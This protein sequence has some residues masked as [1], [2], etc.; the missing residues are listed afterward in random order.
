MASRLD[1]NSISFKAIYSKAF[2]FWPLMAVVY[3]TTSILIG[4]GF[5]AL[6]IPG[7]IVM[8]RTSYAQFYCV[9]E[10]KGPIEAIKKSWNETR[11]NQWI[12]LIGLVVMYS[13]IEVTDW[14][15][16]KTLTA[17]GAH[18]VFVHIVASILN[19]TLFSLPIVFA[20]RMYSDRKATIKEQQD[21]VFEL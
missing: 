11:E 16:S 5:L 14:M 4:V 6:I 18:Y 17:I 19:C 21:Q 15:A 9:L 7:L 1:G 12:L 8:A 13:A 3:L 2:R 20:F 10:N